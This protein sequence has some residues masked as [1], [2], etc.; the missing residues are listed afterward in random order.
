MNRRPVAQ[1]KPPQI[2][3]RVRHGAKGKFP[4]PIPYMMRAPMI[5]DIPFI[6]THVATRIGCSS[7]LYQ[8]L[9]IIMNAGETVPGQIL[10][11][12]P[13]VHPPRLRVSKYLTF[14]ES[15][16]KPCSC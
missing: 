9:V 8:I 5:W 12:D 6:E 1:V 14:G 15:Q 4:C 10:D 7:R 3:K 16:E 2:K 13:L 11:L